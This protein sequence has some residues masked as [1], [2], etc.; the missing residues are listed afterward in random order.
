M[1]QGVFLVFLTLLFL[2][3]RVFAGEQKGVLVK[4]YSDPVSFDWKNLI[5]RSRLAGL[6]VLEGDHLVLITDCPRRIGDD[7]E[8]LPEIFDEAVNVWADHYGIPLSVVS[9]WKVCGCLIVDRERFREAGLLPDAIPDFTN[10]Y[11]DHYRFW[12]IDQ[13]NPAYRRHLL[14]HE[15]VHAFTTTLLSLNTP[16]WYTEGIAEWLATHRLATGV[17]QFQHT[18]V[19]VTPEDVEQ[20]GRIEMIRRLRQ[21]AEAPS[22]DEVFAMKPTLHGTIRSYAS[23]W[24]A[25]AFLAGHP[26][27]REAFAATE[28]KPL[29]RSFTRRMISQPGW[30]AFTARRDFDAFTAD[31]DY[32]FDPIRMAIDWSRSRLLPANG[33]STTVK[34]SQGWQT[35][36]WRM[37]AGR[38]YL[39]RASGRCRVGQIEQ[40]NGVLDLES[41]ADG[42]SVDWYRGRPVGRLLVAQWDESPASGERPSFQILGE[43]GDVTFTAASDGP[44][45]LKI[46]NHPVSLP[47]SHGHLAIKVGSEAESILRR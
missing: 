47:R 32:G 21:V 39:L 37:E 5:H 40:E 27:Y 45:F 18:P 9:D 41:T 12:F 46:N 4:T 13:S 33:G 1:H 24:A 17:P 31:L 26:R 22:L 25:V 29:D 15:G 7:L 6:Q 19:P 28:K 43:G 44:L 36:G 2:P 10:G 30:D 35:T 38:R 20:L 34:A 3:V 11:C 23:A 16:T 42:I 14:L 8:T